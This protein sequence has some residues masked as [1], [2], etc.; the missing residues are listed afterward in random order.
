MRSAVGWSQPKAPTNA[1]HLSRSF[2]AIMGDAGQQAFQQNATLHLFGGRCW[3]ESV[4]VTVWLFE[5]L[6][7]HDI[8]DKAFNDDAFD[9]GNSGQ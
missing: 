3:I 7:A 6:V 4:Q 9:H 5:P 1:P 8:F 2:F